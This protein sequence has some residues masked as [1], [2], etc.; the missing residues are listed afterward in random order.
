MVRKILVITILSLLVFQ[1]SVLAEMTEGEIVFRD[2]LYGAAIG[3]IIGSA[4]YMIDQ[5]DFVEKVG[6]GIAIG[7]FG[8]LF[9]GLTET[10]SVVEI[11][12]DKIKVAFPKPVIQKGDNNIRYSAS[13]LKVN[14]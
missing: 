7:T 3:A 10:R 11:E 14:F 4:I 6:V 1:G 8:G 12:R 2:A 13:L 9:F 5:E